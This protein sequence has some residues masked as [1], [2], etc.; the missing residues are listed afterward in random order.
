MKTR[1]CLDF[2]RR[3]EHATAVY[4]RGIL[5]SLA[6]SLLLGSGTLHAQG[7]VKVPFPYSPINYSAMPFMIAKEARLFEKYGL[8]VR[9]DIF[10]CIIVDSSVDALRFSQPSWI[11]RAGDHF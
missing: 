1:Y 9:S 2:K 4:R 6:L 11:R 7:L 5:F 3:I 8:D 10:R